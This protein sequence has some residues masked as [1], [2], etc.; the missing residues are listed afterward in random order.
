MPRYNPAE[1]EP[2]WQAYWQQHGTF[3][4][5][6]MPDPAKPKLYALDM[7]P[8]P[9]GDGLHVG[10]PE[11]Y[12]ATDILS[13]YRRMCG[14]NV[15]HP[16]GFDAFGLPAEEHA[17]KTN[18]PP[19]EQTEKN[20][21]TFRR[22]LRMLGFSYDWDRELATTD[23]EYFR[24]TQWIFLILF[25]TWY[26][27][28]QG[29][30]R[31]ISELPIPAEVQAEGEDAVRRYQDE[32]RLA[33]QCDA[34]VNW[35]PAL[36]TVL[37]NEEVIDGRSERGS[38]PVQRIPLRQWMLRITAYADR[39][40]HG[41]DQLDWPDSVKALQRNW[42]GRSTGAE[43][44]FFIGAS[45]QFEGW[46]SGRATSGWPTKPSDDV[47]RIYTTRPDT[48]FGATYMVIAPEHPF[49][50]RLTTP[51]Q[52]AA[53]DS[54]CQAASSKSDLER[55]ELT[56]TKTGVFTG[57]HAINPVNGQPVPIWIADYVLISYGTGA[58]MAVPAHDTRDF[59][60]AQ[61][62]DIPIL[63]VV[64]PGTAPDV[65]RDR[66]LSGS[67]VFT[68]MGLAINSGSYDGMPTTQFKQQ[69]T[70]DL[71]RQG[72]GKT[73]VNYKL[74]DWLFSRQRFWGEPFPILHELDEQ[75]KPNGLLRAVDPSE[76]PVD[77]P[78]LDDY[79]PHGRP[80]PPL[81]K[82]PESWLYVTKD[83]KR[84]RR[85]T[86]TMPQ[87]A[88][89]CWYYLRFIDPRNNQQFIAPER[90]AAWMPVD[91]YVGGAEHAVLHLLYSRFW[92]QVL[93]DRGYVSTAEPFQKLVNQGMILG[94]M[95][96]TGYQDAQGQWVSP[97]QVTRDAEGQWVLKADQTPVV[98]KRLDAAEV[99]KEG[100][101]FV[102]LENPTVSVDSRSYKMSKSR[103][104]VVNPDQIVREYGAD[105]LRLYEMFMGPLEAPKP[106]SMK[107][108]DGV[109]KFL[110]RAWR[111]II[112]D[113]ADDLQLSS[114]VTDEPATEEQLRVLHKTIKAV[115]H[116]L[117]T[118]SFNTAIARL[119]EFVNYF[120]KES[121]RSRDILEP[122]VLLI[123]PMAP[124]LAEELWAL[125]GHQQTLSYEPWPTFDEAL[126]LDATIE[127]PVQIL[128]KVRG[129]IVVPADADQQL[130]EQTAKSDER[131]AALLEG[132]QIVKTI[133]VPGRLVNFVTRGA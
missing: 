69:I 33:Y 63:A 72:L 73:A 58:I 18:T 8:Y 71:H 6:D 81:A 45:E 113:R 96:Y 67:E 118:M 90:E 60:F 30:G 19:R 27:G 11:G 127:V 124:H 129:K 22:Q 85:E 2:K 37:A 100:E 70:E 112:E 7:F 95:E 28:D 50:A 13:R 109:R 132:K 105:S 75:G 49:V 17:I 46:K 32:N 98:T 53:V 133:V 130:I 35:C 119:M 14:Y 68:D 78:H 9:S 123:S 1:I 61:Q 48:L 79:K 77:L 57:S 107:G 108:V 82:A 101:Q 122:F 38:H 23:V 91:L 12:T 74:R 64:D 54:Y 5:P 3:R 86:N 25:D 114:S 21:A 15:L 106:W 88:G 26:D 62:F 83:G 51:E 102:L 94:E 87:W 40:Q 16:M 43:V 20:I 128:G 111:L 10:H 103:G 76:L 42:I 34:L 47:L 125:L 99:T 84:Y 126:T 117:D 59:E 36:G 116:D 24:W 92:H 65:D 29:K 121:K 52:Q 80:E 110:D 41:L 55:T 97:S 120:T 66:V 56:K 31:P 104:N 44:D 131:I 39:L 4:S 115:T 89:S 93:F